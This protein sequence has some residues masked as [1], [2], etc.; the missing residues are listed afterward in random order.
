MSVNVWRFDGTNLKDVNR[1]MHEWRENA[2]DGHRPNIESPSPSPPSEPQPPSAPFPK[3]GTAWGQGGGV[4]AKLLPCD[5]IPPQFKYQAP[6]PQDT[7]G[8]NPKMTMLDVGV[9][10]WR[11]TAGIPIPKDA[12][13]V[14]EEAHCGKAKEAGWC[15]VC[16]AGN[17]AL[18]EA[19]CSEVATSAFCAD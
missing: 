11:N 5:G 6:F 17:A 8:S 18:K 15:Y 3:K 10:Y 9:Q 2:E 1:T 16:V 7:V 4:L 12:C 13:M 14:A 19:G